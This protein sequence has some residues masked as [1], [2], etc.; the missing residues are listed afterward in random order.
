MEKW[1]QF[2]NEQVTIVGQEAVE[3]W[4]K[5]LRILRFDACNLYLE[6]EDAFQVAWFREQ[7]VPHLRS[8]KNNNQRLIKVHLSLRNPAAQNVQESYNNSPIS[9]T[10]PTKKSNASIQYAANS[11][12][13]SEHLV[14]PFSFKIGVLNPFA[15]LENFITPADGNLLPLSIAHEAI[16]SDYPVYNPIYFHGPR[17]SGKTHLLMSLAA[18]WKQQNRQALYVPAELF[19]EHLVNAIRAGEMHAFRRLYRSLDALLIDNVQIF[20]RKGAT[21]EELFHTFNA[22]HTDGKQIILAGDAPPEE[23]KEIEPR[24]I[25]RFGWG[26]VLPLVP[27]NG[28]AIYQLL[29]KRLEYTQ[30]KL[31]QEARHFLLETF[32]SPASLM[33]AIDIILFRK[34]HDME[35]SQA[36]ETNQL[37]S[38][39]GDLLEKHRQ[40]LLTPEELTKLVAKEFQIPYADLLGKSQARE[41]SFPRKVAIFLCRIELEMPFVKIGTFFSRDHSTIMSSTRTVQK[42][43]NEGDSYLT[44]TILAIL[45]QL[46]QQYQWQSRLCRTTSSKPATQ[47]SISHE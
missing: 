41:I 28:A 40:I 38:L 43:W 35:N 29:D 39:L 14:E 9:H 5:P 42:S 18:A 21:Q 6:A 37:Y 16:L 4:L 24:L 22:L 46:Q 26:L 17:A 45:K 7:I 30:L 33:Q 27:L 23:L 36:L 11:P 44:Q 32:T 31:T 20:S 8:F 12:Q 1:H 2:V 47:P 25:S 15:T 19:T 34:R 3:K 10:S 13:G